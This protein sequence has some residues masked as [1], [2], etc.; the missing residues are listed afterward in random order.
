MLR[1]CIG[2][3][4]GVAI[5]CGVNDECMRENGEVY[6]AAVMHISSFG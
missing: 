2:G 3:G 6:I 5:L 4:R 1:C